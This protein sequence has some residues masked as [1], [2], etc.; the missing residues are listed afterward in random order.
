MDEVQASWSHG[1]FAV[2]P[3]AGMLTDLVFD[4]DGTSFRPLAR[5]PWLDDAQG[6]TECSSQTHLDVLGGEFPCVPFGADHGHGAN[7][8]WSLELDDGGVSGR[9]DYP[10]R[11]AVRRLERRIRPVPGAPEIRFELT[12]E[13]RVDARLPLG[14]H[15]VLR[16]PAVPGALSI[17]ATFERG[18]THP[19]SPSRS[20]VTSHGTRFSDLA[21]VP[22]PGG[23]VDLSRL[24]LASDETASQPRTGVDD[25]GMLCGARSPITVHYLEEDVELVLAWDDGVLPSVNYWYSDRGISEQPWD[26]RYRGLGLEPANA[27]FDYGAERSVAPNSLTADGLTTSVGLAAG[28]RLTVAYSLGARSRTTVHERTA[29][30]H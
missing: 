26:G 25:G 8:V 28:T 16:L 18:Y 29:D 20:T 2:T 10:A 9:I 5:A 11:S 4:L 30:A 22:A 1:E 19:S 17:H 7:A 3:V 15:P 13:A 24:P 14:V 6:V 21:A 23:T 12:V 27:Y